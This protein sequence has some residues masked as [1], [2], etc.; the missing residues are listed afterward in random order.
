MFRTIPML[1]FIGLGAS[2]SLV[3]W[4][5]GVKS[6]VVEVRGLAGCSG[7]RIGG[8]GFFGFTG[9][10]WQRFHDINPKP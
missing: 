9:R 2:G 3:F 4:G 5:F 7:L 8:L 10:V 6:R 1:V